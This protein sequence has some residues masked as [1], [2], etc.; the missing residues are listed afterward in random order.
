LIESLFVL[1]AHLA[2]AAARE[3]RGSHLVTRTWLR[4]QGAVASALQRLIRQVYRPALEILLEWRYLT[5]AA[6]VSI[7]LIAMAILGGGWLRF[8]FQ[9]EVEGDVAVA[10]LTM[11]LGTSVEVTSEAVSHLVRAAE[12]VR[13]EVDAERETGSIFAHVFDAVGEQPY[14]RRQAASAT[15]FSEAVGTGSH[16]GEVEIEVVPSEEREITVEELTRRWRKRTGMIPGAVELSFASNL[17]A[18]AAPIH[19]EL[20][21]PD[22]DELVSAAER[23]KRALSV[24]PGVID[25]SDSFR[26][27][28]QEIELEILPDAEALGLTLSDLAGQVRQAFYGHEVQRIQRGRDDVR[29]VV[30]YP[31]E[32]RR[33]LGDLERMRIRATDGSAVPFTSVARATLG[34]GFSSIQREDRRR[35]VSVTAAVDTRMANANEIVA[36]LKRKVVPDIEAIY[37]RLQ[38]SFGGEQRE[39]AEVLGSLIRGWI[40]ALF[41]IYALLAVPLRS[42]V[43]PLIIMA[44]IPF[45]LVGAIGGH[46]IMQYKF[47]MMSVVGLVALSGVVVNDSLV[48]VDYINKCRA[49]GAALQDAIREAGAARFRAVLLTSL[50]T[51]A[52][53]TPLLL[54]QS[55]QAKLLIPMGISLAFGVIFATLITLVIVPVSYLILEDLLQVAGRLFGRGD[56]HDEIPL[57]VKPAAV[58][59]ESGSWS[60]MP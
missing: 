14:R 15:A 39:Q 10:Y 47:S 40:I 51:F 28:K 3:T 46:L 24:Y 8:V 9:P 37:P 50:T 59:Q 60:G 13:R 44:A 1:P 2:F 38:I 31:A 25:I 26:G 29:V 30:R 20:A 42:Y 19:L 7:L 23:L 41:A 55:V 53:L 49:K 35:V 34:R 18:A 48:L 33:S 52:G 57:E 58:A 21:G 4:F 32:D 56:L 5:V 17:I 6:G 22:L 45:G 43:Q 12:E 16:L 36:D 54:E 11:P 27:G